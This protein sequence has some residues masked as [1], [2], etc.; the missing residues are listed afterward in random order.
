M[1]FGRVTSD[2]FSLDFTFPFCPLQAFGIALTS[3]YSRIARE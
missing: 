2:A 3:F 1:Q